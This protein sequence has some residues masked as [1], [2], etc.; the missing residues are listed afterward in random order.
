ML[1]R[2]IIAETALPAVKKG[3]EEEQ[4]DRSLWRKKVVQ[5]SEEERQK[6]RDFVWLVKGIENPTEGHDSNILFGKK[7]QAQ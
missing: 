3:M 4:G 7:S 6:D 2:D 5:Q 1:T